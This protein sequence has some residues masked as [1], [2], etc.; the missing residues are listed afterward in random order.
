MYCNTKS[1][2]ITQFLYSWN[3]KAYV[4]PTLKVKTKCSSI[5]ISENKTQSMQ[6]S[7]L[8]ICEHKANFSKLALLKK[9]RCTAVKH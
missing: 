8:S 6:V 1:K 2:L 5:R 9:K 3:F 4:E 7:H